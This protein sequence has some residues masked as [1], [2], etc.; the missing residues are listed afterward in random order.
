MMRP[1]FPF[2]ALLGFALALAPVAR[3]GED[4]RVA[5]VP[6][7][8]VLDGVVDEAPWNAAARLPAE[9]IQMPV[10]PPADGTASVTPVVRLLVADGRLW[11]SAEVAED[12]GTAM[13]LH[14]L[15]AADDAKS[16]ADAVSLG[17]RPV[18]LRAPRYAV[19][20]PRGAGRTAYRLQG[21]ASWKDVGRW[22]LEACVPLVDLVGE[23]TDA[24]LRV[25][26]VVFSRTP[27]VVAASPP[28]VRWTAPAR[29]QR[30]LPPEGGWPTEADV[31]VARIQKEDRADRARRMLWLR[32]KSA[33]NAVLPHDLPEQELRARVQAL[34]L[35]PLEAMLEHA[36]HLRVPVQVLRG[37]TL[38]RLGLADAAAAE[39]EDAVK[40]APGWREAQYG[41]RVQLWG[42][43]LAAGTPGGPTDHEAAAKR[44]DA[45][46]KEHARDP[47]ALEGIALARGLLL[48]RGGRFEAAMDVLDTLRRR[49]PHDA[50]VDAHWVFARRAL[51]AWPEELRRRKRDAEREVPR[52]VLNTDAGRIVLELFEDDVP[53][54][55]NNFVWLAK[56][57]FYDDVPFHRV[58]PFFAL[59]GGDPHARE[60][61]EGRP[62][63]GTP[64]YAIRTE[65]GERFP[66]RGAV[67]MASMGRDTEGS[68]FFVLTGTA[69][70]LHKEQAIFGRVVSGQET[71]E[72]LRA[73]DR[74]RSVVLDGLDPERTYR[75]MTVAGTPAPE[76]KKR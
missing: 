55:V 14:L 29:W 62:G 22:S 54:T 33:S 61:S 11:V 42:P 2:F 50:F 38:L 21:E 7:A 24:P 18:D 67:A 3:A 25:A 5:S 53:N 19:R 71:A 32:Y 58:L 45:L 48:Y 8:P 6:Q 27:N 44:L 72:R 52:A 23:A 20:G 26:A 74:I 60:G 66:F 9:E 41:L 36:P 31:D 12:P 10:P 56:H 35:D 69:A 28:G 63:T 13:G 43:G 37:D 64:G 49:Y 65:V 76:P 16:A 34:L 47:W 4:L 15:V 40:V 17:F 39:F 1:T 70:H 73:G 57:G 75:P 30:I 46:A 59:Q 68:Q 51:Q